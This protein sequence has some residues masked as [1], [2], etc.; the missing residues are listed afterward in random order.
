MHILAEQQHHVNN[1]DRQDPVSENQDKNILEQT[2][3][4]QRQGAAAT[5]GIV[6]VVGVGGTAVASTLS[7]GAKIGTLANCW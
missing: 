2:K 3:K 5:T 4:I 6:V 1:N 7:V